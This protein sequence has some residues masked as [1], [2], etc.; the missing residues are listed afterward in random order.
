MSPDDELGV[1]I[2]PP[3]THHKKGTPAEEAV[4]S[5]APTPYSGGMNDCI[6]VTSPRQSG[7]ALL[8]RTPK[9]YP[10]PAVDPAWRTR[11]DRQP[12]GRSRLP[13]GTF[14]VWSPS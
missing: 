10:Q 11:I 13:D 2:P 3:T 5:F 4:H 7:K 12:R 1:N 9:G 14:G 6:S 8:A